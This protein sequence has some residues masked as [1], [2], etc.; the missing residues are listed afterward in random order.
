MVYSH[1]EENHYEYPASEGRYSYRMAVCRVKV[2]FAIPRGL[3]L[4]I[5][6]KG[7]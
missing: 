5:S 1:N 4:T 3:R 2:I 6:L 7:R